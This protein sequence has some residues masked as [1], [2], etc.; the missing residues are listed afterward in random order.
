MY[1]QYVRE[2]V[3]VYGV[4]AVRRVAAGVGV[5]NGDR[6]HVHIGALGS[7]GGGQ[8]GL[9]HP[10]RQRDAADVESGGRV[11][12]GAPGQQVG[13]EPVGDLRHI[14]HGLVV[15]ALLGHGDRGGFGRGRFLRVGGFL[16]RGG[17]LAAVRGG[18]CR[19]AAAGQARRHGKRQQQGQGLG[20]FLSHVSRVLLSRSK[21]I[22]VGIPGRT[23]PVRDGSATTSFCLDKSTKNVAYCRFFPNGFLMHSI[24]SKKHRKSNRYS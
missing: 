15:G 22:A 14:G 4:E 21:I 20:K 17:A 7:V 10:L 19:G 12:L 5:H 6:Y 1:C 3:G 23:R 24:V 8:A 13:R 18:G 16:L 11:A 9:I 2:H